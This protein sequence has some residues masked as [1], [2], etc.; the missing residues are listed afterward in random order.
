MTGDIYSAILPVMTDNTKTY[1]VTLGRDAW[2]ETVVKV[3]ADSDEQAEELALQKGADVRYDEWRTE[4]RLP[5]DEAWGDDM[6]VTDYS[7]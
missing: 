6:R 2:V 7:K 1:Y 5:N 3:Q 4:L